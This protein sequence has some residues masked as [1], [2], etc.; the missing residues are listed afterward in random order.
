VDGTVC[1]S[2]AGH[3][4][5]ANRTAAVGPEVATQIAGLLQNEK[6]RLK[7]GEIFWLFAIY[8]L[9]FAYSGLAG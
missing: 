9:L 2:R 8:Y 1:A 7:R 5:W 4:K 3:A 6:S